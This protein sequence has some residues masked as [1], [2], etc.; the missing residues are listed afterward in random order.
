MS[1]MIYEYEDYCEG[2]PIP[3]PEP[4]VKPPEIPPEVWQTKPADAEQ[5]IRAVR[6]LCGDSR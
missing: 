2:W 3:V 5:C 6:A 1:Q 4:K